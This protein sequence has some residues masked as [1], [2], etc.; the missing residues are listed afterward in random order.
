MKE[1]E[2]E[3]LRRVVGVELSWERRVE[4]R[5]TEVVKMGLTE[6]RD[7][8]DTWYECDSLSNFNCELKIRLERQSQSGAFNAWDSISLT[9][10]YIISLHSQSCFFIY[11]LRT[12]FSSSFYLTIT[13]KLVL[14]RRVLNK[15]TCF[16]FYENYYY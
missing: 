7:S 2:R 3:T 9:A 4:L 14:T 11:F 15:G 10:C 12:S 16:L 5:E 1:R 6:I 13:L 8:I